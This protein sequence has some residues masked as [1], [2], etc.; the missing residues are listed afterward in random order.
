MVGPF[1][2]FDHMGPAVF[3]A[4]EGIDVRPHPHIGLAT[5]TYLFEGEIHHRDSLGVHQ[6]I[7]PGDVNWMTAGRGIVHS[8]RTGPEERAR[9]ARLDGIQSWLALPLAHEDTAPD[10]AH[11]PAATLPK[12][13]DDDLTMTLI[14]GTA[15]GETAP[16]Q[17][18]SEM[19]YLDCDAGAGDVVL[20]MPGD[21]AERAL[22]VAHGGVEVDGTVIGEGQMAVLK[23]RAAVTIRTTE[24]SRVMLIGGAP[25]DGERLMWWNFVASS[26]DKLDAAKRRWK[27]GGLEMVPGDD[28][29]IPLPED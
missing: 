8:E 22:Y 17:V 15:L 9:A 6:P 13:E 16:P 10:F 12:I 21:H 26:Q 3:P 24:A 28:E 11:H 27:H 2:F 19:F 25:M 18:F 29:F 1:I 14:A 20:P 23:E 7:R 5:V 4:G